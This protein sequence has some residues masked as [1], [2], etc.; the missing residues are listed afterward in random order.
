MSSPTLLSFKKEACE[1]AGI[2]QHDGSHVIAGETLKLP[3]DIKLLRPTIFP[4]V[5][6]PYRGLAFAQPSQWWLH[7]V[8]R[9]TESLGM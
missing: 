8:R 4:S 9:K 5:P 6:R 1:V 3:D 2:M 7:G